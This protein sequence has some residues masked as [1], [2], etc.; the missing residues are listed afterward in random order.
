MQEEKV[1]NVVK[2][3]LVRQFEFSFKPGSSPVSE[4]S[5][6]RN[7]FNGFPAWLQRETVEPDQH[8]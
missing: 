6:N 7:R 2:G 8:T 4:G 5:N 3:R 1:K